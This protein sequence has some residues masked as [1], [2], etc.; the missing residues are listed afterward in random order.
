MQWFIFS[1]VW[2]NFYSIHIS[3]QELEFCQEGLSSFLD[4]TSCSVREHGARS[5]RK[6]WVITNAVKTQFLNRNVYKS[7]SSSI[8]H[9][10]SGEPIW[11][12][13]W[14]PRKKSLLFKQPHI[15]K[16]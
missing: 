14:T 3:I 1:C 6:N 4:A 15:R 9:L 7:S 5:K 13:N 10:L 11:R 2:Y 12:S 8:T 16:N